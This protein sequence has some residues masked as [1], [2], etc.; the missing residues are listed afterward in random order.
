MADKERLADDLLHGAE[1]IAE[2]T[3]LTAR[4]IYHQQK[5]LGLVHLGAL[6]IGSKTKLR[7]LLTGEAA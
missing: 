4:Q 5:N 7:K 2:Y 6:L 3:G 1:E